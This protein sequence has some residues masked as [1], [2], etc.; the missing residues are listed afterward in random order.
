VLE[1]VSFQERNDIVG[2]LPL[3]LERAAATMPATGQA[4]SLRPG[5]PA[6]GR[7]R[8]P[9]SALA[10]SAARACA[11]TPQMAEVVRRICT[12]RRLHRQPSLAMLWPSLL[13]NGTPTQSRICKRNRRGF[14]KTGREQGAKFNAASP[15]TPASFGPPPQPSMI[16]AHPCAPMKPCCRSISAAGKATCGPYLRMG[17]SPLRNWR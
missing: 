13:R 16:S 6:A 3:D 10:A 12:S 15:S 5:M 8:R 14:G 7:D 4:G 11:R 9:L 1:V 17:Q 2:R